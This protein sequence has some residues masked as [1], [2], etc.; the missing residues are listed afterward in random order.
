M[1]VFFQVA[2]FEKEHFACFE[3]LTSGSSVNFAEHLA[4]V[5]AS[6]GWGTAV[7]LFAIATL[8]TSDVWTFYRGKWLVYRPRFRIRSDG[9]VIGSWQYHF[10]V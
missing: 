5:S 4:T 9:S 6:G 3:Q 7:E 8:L 10:I 1:M 2:Q